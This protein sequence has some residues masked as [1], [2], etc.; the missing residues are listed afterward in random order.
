VQQIIRVLSF[1]ACVRVYFESSV[2]SSLVES[3]PPHRHDVHVEGVRGFRSGVL[4][5]AV[6]RGRARGKWSW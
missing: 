1:A 6:R 4:W 5:V 2:C 3:S